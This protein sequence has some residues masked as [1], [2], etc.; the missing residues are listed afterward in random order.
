MSRRNVTAHNYQKVKSEK[1]QTKILE[2]Q[3]IFSLI[4]FLYLHQQAI[5]V[6]LLLAIHIHHSTCVS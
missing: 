2:M 4:N 6:N 5:Y 3:F 1:E